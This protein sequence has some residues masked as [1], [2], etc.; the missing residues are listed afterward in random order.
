MAVGQ[1]IRNIR[2]R[3]GISQIQ[4]ARM[5]GISNSFLSDVE[6]G[7]REMSL[8]TLKKIAAALN[9]TCS[10]LLEEEA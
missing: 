6:N 8:S 4:L 10:A 5:V 3:Q 9:T 7:R 2:Q 1:L